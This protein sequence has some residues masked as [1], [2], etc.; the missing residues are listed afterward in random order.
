ML[1]QRSRTVLRSVSGLPFKPVVPSV[2]LL[3]P[4]HLRQSSAQTIHLQSPLPRPFTH[5]ESTLVNRWT[6]LS[7]RSFS[8]ARTTRKDAAPQTP[9]SSKAQVPEEP[10]VEFKRT[11]KGEAAKAVDLS[12]RL[13]DRTQEKGEVIRLLKLAAR[14]WRTLSGTVLNT[15][16]LIAS[17]NSLTVY[18]LR[19]SNVN[20]LFHR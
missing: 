3:P 20:P 16:I 6:F 18:F 19:G 10:A 13:K 17:R 12:A 9:A 2:H 11:E 15:S 5:V 14:E 1:V 7:K 8:S 4:F